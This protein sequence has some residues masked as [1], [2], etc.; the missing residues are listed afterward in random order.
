[1]NWDRLDT[2]D[3]ACFLV[4][5]FAYIGA[6]CAIIAYHTCNTHAP[7][8][9]ISS[10][11]DL[12]AINVSIVAMALC[13]TAAGVPNRLIGLVFAEDLILLGTLV[14]VIIAAGGVFA[15]RIQ[16]TREAPKWTILANVSPAGGCLCLPCCLLGITPPPPSAVTVGV[17]YVEWACK[18]DFLWWMVPE[19]ASVEEVVRAESPLGDAHHAVIFA[20]AAVGGGMLYGL[21]FPE[22]YFPVSFDLIGNSHNI[23]HV[24]YGI[25]LIALTYDCFT[26]ALVH[27][28]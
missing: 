5:A 21:K 1:M 13:C 2:H 12:L 23:W 16:L 7:A 28:A 25:A 8:Y 10:A 11:S 18:V 24:A 3:R 9:H 19:G 17:A 20:V 22:R 26:A 4:A 14:T 15:Y 6:T 27:G